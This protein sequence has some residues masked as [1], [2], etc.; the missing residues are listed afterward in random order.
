MMLNMTKT[1]IIK[2]MEINASPEP[3]I[4]RGMGPIKIRP[5]PSTL[6]AGKLPIRERNMPMT[7]SVNP[8][9]ISIIANAAKSL[10]VLNLFQPPRALKT[11]SI[12]NIVIAKAMRAIFMPPLTMTGIGPIKNTA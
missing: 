2:K 9:I 7:T 1:S 8:R 11:S 10:S 12:I 5:P 3:V 6:C 4:I